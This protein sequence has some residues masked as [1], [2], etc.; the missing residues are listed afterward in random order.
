MIM[1]W[2]RI[3]DLFLFKILILK[4]SG[5]FIFFW[6]LPPFINNF[7]LLLT[8]YTNMI[9][10]FNEIMQLYAKDYRNLTE[11]FTKQ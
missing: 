10:V 9:V 7:S 11:D 1:M 2:S 4:M 6:W 3:I 5:N 8:L